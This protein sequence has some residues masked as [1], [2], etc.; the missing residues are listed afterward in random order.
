M[1]TFEIMSTSA[2]ETKIMVDIPI[3]APTGAYNLGVININ[4]TSELSEQLYTI[5]DPS[6][7][8]PELNKITPD[9]SFPQTIDI[10][11]EGKNFTGAT[12]IKFVTIDL[13]IVYSQDIG[14]PTTDTTILATVDL[15][16][17]TEGF[18]YNQVHTPHGYNSIRKAQFEISTILDLNNFTGTATTT[19]SI[20][21][22]D[23]GIVPVYVTL[24]TPDFE[25][26]NPVGVNKAKIE[27]EIDP[28]TAILYAADGLDN[29]PYS[30]IVDPPRQI[31]VTPE[32]IEKLGPI[33]ILFSIGSS[34]HKL[35]FGEE[36][37]IFVRIDITMPDSTSDPSIYYI[38][39]DG[40][41]SL[42]GIEGIRFE[43]MIKKG[44]TI[45][46]RRIGI[47]ETG[48]TSY[49]F[50]LL[51]DHMSKFAVGIESQNLSQTDS[52]QE[53][54]NSGEESDQ[55]GS[56]EDDLIDT[57]DNNLPS[58]PLPNNNSSD[59][60]GNCFLKH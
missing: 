3:G 30:G 55:S 36:Q 59:E 15:S 26:D 2:N 16:D 10:E 32:L 53:E 27:V 28:G 50:G 21:M 22:P 41:I 57:T 45:L 54:V 43:K 58:T 18:Y 5:T 35:I 24:T 51:L 37:V 14:L 7:S 42:A 49:T 8:V 44:G 48:L 39:P 19:G 17:L 47:P 46:S 1:L 6:H 60:K 20:N 29:V 4:G 56:I 25:L 23:N 38:E 34:S 31:P 52:N 11:L 12:A 13:L 40:N 9:V 33:A